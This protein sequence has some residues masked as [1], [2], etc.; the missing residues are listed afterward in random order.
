MAH[1]I[2]IEQ[3]R[4]IGIIA[5]IDAGKTTTTER[6]LYYTGLIHRMGEVDEGTAFTDYMEQ[7]RE[8]GITIT[9]A[10]VT[11]LWRGYQINIID[12]PG[13][14]DFTAEVQRA[15]RVLDGAVV[16]FCGVAGVQPQSEAVWHHADRYDVPRIAYVNK[17][18][19]LGANFARV[20][21]MIRQRLG[22]RPVAVHLPMGEGE[23]LSGVI[24]LITLQA[25]VFDPEV[26]GARYEALSIPSSYWDTARV[27]REQLLE[28]IADTD[29]TLLERYLSGKELH[30]EEIRSALRK[31]T[32]QRQLV[33]VCCGSSL[34]NIGVQLLLDAIVDYL[35]SP[36]DIGPVRGYGINGRAE[37]TE[38][39]P[40]DDEAPA[41]ALCFKVLSDP[42]VGR[43]SFIRIYS[44]TLRQGQIL[45]NATAGKQERLHKL[46]RM[47]AN[48]REELNEARAGD[49]IAIPS[50]RFSRT[51]DT[52]CDPQ[53]P[54]IF[55]PIHFSPPVINQAIE[56]RTA[57]DQ[58]RLLE[59]L[60]RFADEDP[61][62]EYCVDEETGQILIRGVGEL[63]LE[64]IVDRLQREFGIAAR[65]GRPYVS[66]RETITEAVQ[67]EGK[68]LRA[69]QGGSYSHYGHVVLEL[70]PGER[71]SGVIFENALT[72][73]LL[74]A[75][76]VPAIER[77]IR[78]A[79]VSGPVAGYPVVDIVVR[80]IGAS[81][82]ES[83]SSETD[84]QAAATIA[85][86]E[87]TARAKPVL[88]EPVMLVEVLAPEEALGDIL[89]DLS[90]RRGR[91]E[92]V[93][94]QG[95]FHLA[96]AYVPLAEMF[97]YVT[98]LRSLTQGRGA[99]TMLFSHY[100]PV[101]QKV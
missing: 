51:G 54:I 97:G 59:A 64:I 79:A 98:Q 33:P 10:A 88:L 9:S 46:L 72:E 67:Q 5:H 22:S 70:L 11:C 58:D 92:S 74:P 56:A 32:L 30:P 49:I 3:L 55:E 19:R 76:F 13:H 75:P 47:Y 42:Y 53:H 28:A 39:R 73:P 4:N 50:L 90:A 100:E 65:V 12:T 41:A 99:Y 61:T 1:R 48:R 20:L 68:F 96:R 57:A 25:Y 18:D 69:A 36:S 6:I 63:H 8:R 35:P 45:L 71:N 7:E 66:Y 14:V 43:L 44:G 93:E 21:E 26:Y 89:A 34:R 77:A 24:D 31:G 62:F 85:F 81:Y 23:A 82:R 52:L 60:Q 29:D 2:P 16:I 40:P 101:P 17:M 37:T 38:M 78:S 80:L 27:Y 83:E 86:R 91:I 95:S 94:V 15:L 87:G 84:Y